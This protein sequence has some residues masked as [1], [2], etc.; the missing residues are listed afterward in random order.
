MKTKQRDIICTLATFVGGLRERVGNTAQRKWQA[1][2][3]HATVPDLLA[4]TELQGKQILEYVNNRAPT[5]LS[6][7]DGLS[8]TNAGPTFAVPVY[9][10]VG[11]QVAK[12]LQRSI[13]YRTGMALSQACKIQPGETFS[14]DQRYHIELSDDDIAATGDGTQW[15]WVYGVFRYR[16][17]W[18]MKHEHL[19]CW[20]FANFEPQDEF[21]YFTVVA[22]PL[23]VVK[24][25]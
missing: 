10:A 20:R 18:S 8:F 12:E 25:V 6:V 2:T 22:A 21:Y 23:S 19:F 16:D 3:F 7:I 15:L 1:P 17:P 5:K 9:L 13:L 11:W 24:E 14:V 4:I